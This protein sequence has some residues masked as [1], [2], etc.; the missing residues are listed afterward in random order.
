MGIK[1]EGKAHYEYELKRR[2]LI[3][4]ER[5]DELARIAREKQNNVPKAEFSEKAL[6]IIQAA[7]LRAD[8]KGNVKLGDRTIDAMKELGV[9]FD[10]PHMPKRFGTKGEFYESPW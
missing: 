1:I 2:G 10:H 6:G 9:H 4:Q 3:P 8:K 7:K 5:A